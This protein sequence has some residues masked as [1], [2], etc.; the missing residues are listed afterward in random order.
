MNY[1]QNKRFA[2][3][4]YIIN[5]LTSEDVES[6]ENQWSALRAAGVLNDHYRDNVKDKPADYDGREIYAVRRKS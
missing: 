2:G 5:T 1:T 4:W 6:H 3:S